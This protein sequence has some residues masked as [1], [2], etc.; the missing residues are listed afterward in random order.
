VNGPGRGGPGI[1]S[2]DAG[3][4]PTSIVYAVAVIM[5]SLAAVAAQRLRAVAAEEAGP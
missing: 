1:A 5:L 4:R 3:L 2:T